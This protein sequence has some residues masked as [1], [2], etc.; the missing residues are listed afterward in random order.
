MLD[1]ARSIAQSPFDPRRVDDLSDAELDA[2]SF[3][4]I[5]LDAEGTVLRY[6]LYESRLARL[7]RNQ[8]VG[9][10]FFGDVAHCART[11]AFEGRFRSFLT[12]SAEGQIA[13]FD[14]VFDFKFGAQSVVV[15]LIRAADAPRWYLLINRTSIEPPRPSFP[16]EM[17]AAEQRDL[18]PDEAL[19]GVIRDG[20][21]RRVVDAPA[22]FFAALRATC[23]RLA[24]ETWQL[25][26]TEWGVQWGRRT[27]VDLEASVLE[28]GGRSLREVP[29]REVARLISTYLAERGWGSTSFDFTLTTEGLLVIELERSALAEAAPRPPRT[30]SAPQDDLACHIVAG[31]LSGILSSVA[32][33]RLAAREVACVAG[34]APRCTIVLVAHERRAPLDAALGDGCRGVESIRA[35]L[36]RAPRGIESTR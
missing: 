19:R 34:G 26:A 7:D 13:R 11:E 22:P 33:R 29:M 17:L 16:L 30:G 2:L 14:F 3:G 12:Q 31:C 35:A 28:S 8:V 21:E 9:R 5:A 6:N 20:L 15:E 18:A 10:N 32:D 23:D 36:R 25:F 1:L 27:A 4:V 24:P